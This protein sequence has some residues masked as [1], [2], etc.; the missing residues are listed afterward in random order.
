MSLKKIDANLVRIVKNSAALNVLVHATAI[1]I[2]TH[3]T[4]SGDCSRALTLVKSLPASFR[5]EPLLTW[6]HKYSPLRVVPVNN[7]VG[8]LTKDDKDYKPF[9]LSKAAA[10]PF[11]MIAEKTPEKTPE[12]LGF[13]AMLKWFE[14]QATAWEKKADDETKVKPEDRRTALELARILRSVKLTHMEPGNDDSIEPVMKD[15][16]LAANG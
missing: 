12:P 5:K 9:N 1:L 16:E 14:S 8:M 4:K 2:M 7:V 3:A 10:E 13:A 11:Y 6:F 15:E